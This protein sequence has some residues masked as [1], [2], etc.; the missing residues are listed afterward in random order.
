[1][2]AAT[3]LF[4]FVS[5][6]TDW[7]LANDSRVA[8]HLYNIRPSTIDKSSAYQHKSFSYQCQEHWTQSL[9]KVI[10]SLAYTGKCTCFHVAMH[11]HSVSE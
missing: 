3:L 1:M 4:S 8:T 9:A 7:P 6:H 5:T 10:A 2:K 11:G